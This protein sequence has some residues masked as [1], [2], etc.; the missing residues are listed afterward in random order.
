MTDV[1]VTLG[2]ELTDEEVRVLLLCGAR[3]NKDFFFMEEG[4]EERD[5]EDYCEGDRVVWYDQTEGEFL[6]GG[7]S[8]ESVVERMDLVHDYKIFLIEKVEEVEFGEGL[9]A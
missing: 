5:P 1:V 7:H 4:Q 8:N 6:E 3:D 9:S 2:R